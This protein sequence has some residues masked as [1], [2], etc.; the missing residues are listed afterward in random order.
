MSVALRGA[1]YE[2]ERAVALMTA[3]GFGFDDREWFRRSC[4]ADPWHSPELHRIC[5]VDGQVVSALRICRRWLRYGES[6]LELAGIGDVTT[7]P[8]HRGKGYSTMVLRDAIA[9]M[10]EHRCDFSILF[11]GIFDF[12]R[13]V[14]YDTIPRR[15]DV[16]SLEDAPSP[17]SF[18]TM[19]E[20]D[21]AKHLSGLMRLHEK[22]GRGRV[23]AMLRTPTYWRG[24]LA[25]R[26]DA[27]QVLV[28]TSE[29]RVTAYA[30]CEYGDEARL[31]ECGHDDERF[32]DLCAVLGQVVSTA[33][34]GGAKSLHVWAGGQAHV[35]SVLRSWLGD[36]EVETERPMGLVV[37]LPQLL[38]RVQDEL[39][40]RLIASELP[41]R[42]RAVSIGADG[43]VVGLEVRDGAL[44]IH[45]GRR[46]NQHAPLEQKDVLELLFAGGAT[47]LDEQLAGLDDSVRRLVCALFP[48]QEFAYSPV[49][50]F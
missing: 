40:R 45:P 38:T 42:A 7:L 1:R 8:E 32:G 36:G 33:R 37:N 41:E 21:E 27:R 49:D 18:A 28:A 19:P 11:T 35:R 34:D 15:R 39:Q 24:R 5:E 3:E 17:P 48:P 20:F 23:G 9:W 47:A 43:H 12:Y 29:G 25:M 4:E 10:G 50:G 6:V 46:A 30:V 13:R 26:S 44:S 16:F 22:A 14:G 31:Y 2:D